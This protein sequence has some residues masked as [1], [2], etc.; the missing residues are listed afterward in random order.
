MAMAIFVA[1]NIPMI[2]SWVTSP[3]L[4]YVETG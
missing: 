1:V 4:R 3:T 2:K